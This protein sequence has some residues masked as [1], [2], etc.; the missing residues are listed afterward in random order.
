MVSHRCKLKVKEELEK[1][2]IDFVVIDLGVVEVFKAISP[3]IR[4]ILK[5]NLHKSGLELL[6]DK[7]SII[8]ERIQNTAVEMIHYNTELPK[9]NASIYISEKLGL[10][11]SLANHA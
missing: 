10:D 11:Y 2:N 6:D 4:E 7:R 9:V 5:I 1:L 3:E 8:I